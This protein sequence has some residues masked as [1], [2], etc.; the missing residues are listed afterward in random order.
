[1]LPE[2]R[3][4]VEAVLVVALWCSPVSAIGAEPADNNGVDISYVYAQFA[5]ANNRLKEVSGTARG[6]S[7]SVSPYR[8]LS[9]GYDNWMNNN[10]E[11]KTI[12]R[13]E[14]QS[15][16]L[17]ARYPISLGNKNNLQIVGSAGARFESISVNN[18]AAEFGN[19]SGYGV[20]EAKW[21]WFRH[22]GIEL[23]G[24]RTFAAKYTDYSIIGA[25]IFLTF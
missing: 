11:S 24:K 8:Y 18:G 3:R 16:F 5:P 9:L 15:I 14:G 10:P 12:H 6:Y 25:G 21:R 17:L 2:L 19:N 4:I 7:V 22:G 23:I 13:V 20:L 1:M